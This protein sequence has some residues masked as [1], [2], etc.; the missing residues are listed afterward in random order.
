MV[1][2]SPK[3]KKDVLEGCSTHAATDTRHL[4]SRRVRGS[5]RL[6]SCFQSILLWLPAA[7]SARYSWLNEALGA[8]SCPVGALL[9]RQGRRLM[10]TLVEERTCSSF[11]ADFLVTLPLAGPGFASTALHPFVLP[12]SLH[13]NLRTSFLEM[14]TCSATS[15]LIRILETFCG[16]A[17]AEPA[18]TGTPAL[19]TQ[20]CPHGMARA[21]V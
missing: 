9:T 3:D 1:S 10:Q 15:G 4:F 7:V 13:A 16:H 21:R 2:T 17:T 6:Q 18:H 19:P 14:L 20:R 11:V 5:Q 12:W 8:L